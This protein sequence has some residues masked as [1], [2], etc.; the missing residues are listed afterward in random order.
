M[1]KIGGLT[2]PPLIIRLYIA[3]CLI[4]KPCQTYIFPFLVN[5]M[6]LPFLTWE[7][8]DALARRV[9]VA[10]LASSGEEN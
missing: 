10:A 1:K 5:A 8:L 4:W 6:H 2:P 3:A 7:S 9:V